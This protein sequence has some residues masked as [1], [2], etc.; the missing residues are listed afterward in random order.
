MVGIASVAITDHLAE[1]HG[2]AGFGVLIFLEN[3]SGGTVTHHE[4]SPVG[5]ER[6]GGIFRVC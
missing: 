5:I 4:A 1:N 2:T 6:E 3:K